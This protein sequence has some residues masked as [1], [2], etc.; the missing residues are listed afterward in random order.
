MLWI[1]AVSQLPDLTRDKAQSHD[2]KRD[3]PARCQPHGALPSASRPTAAVSI[4]DRRHQHRQGPAE[5]TGQWKPGYHWHNFEVVSYDHGPMC[6]LAHGCASNMNHQVELSPEALN[7]RGQRSRKWLAKLS[8]IVVL[9]A[10]TSSTRLAATSAASRRLV[11]E[12]G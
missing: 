2:P 5:M 12:C 8:L 10:I 6:S 9:R 7:Q 1:L 3:R 4:H 11:S